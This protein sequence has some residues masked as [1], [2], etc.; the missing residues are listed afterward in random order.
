MLPDALVAPQQ[1]LLR[2]TAQHSQHY[3]HQMRSPIPRIAVYMCTDSFSAWVGAV[4]G[5][6]VGFFTLVSER[7]PAQLTDEQSP[8]RS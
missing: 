3:L 5:V 6:G 8:C 1:L 2:A 4:C 7:L